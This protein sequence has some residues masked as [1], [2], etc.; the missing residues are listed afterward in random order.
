MNT[1]IDEQIVALRGKRPFCEFIKSKPGS[2]GSNYRLLLRQIFYACTM[3]IH[4]GKSGGVRE[5]KKKGLQAVK[6]MVC[7]M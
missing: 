7:H 6:D 4:T 1:T 2:T 3:Q 5:K